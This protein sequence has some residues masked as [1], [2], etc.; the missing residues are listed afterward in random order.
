MS[1]WNI[2]Y[3]GVDC[4]CGCGGCNGQFCVRVFGCGAE[5]PGA[6]VTF[7]PHGG[8][9]I[10]TGTTD[11]SGKFCLTPNPTA[12]GSYDITA[13]APGYNA[14]SA[15]VSYPCTTNFT[16]TLTFVQTT[17]YVCC[18]TGV[19]QDGAFEQESVPYPFPTPLTLTINC[20]TPST[21]SLANSSGSPCRW[22]NSGGTIV[23]RYNGNNNW[24]LTFLGTTCIITTTHAPTMPLSLTFNLTNPPCDPAAADTP[25]CADTGDIPSTVSVFS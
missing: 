4:S 23:L 8:A 2:G 5:V 13:S 3:P 10:A 22:Q 9:V 17:G 7:A 15:T 1:T 6:T 24:S 11:I 19:F 18:S 20:S 12:A 25:I 21:F 14:A 16:A